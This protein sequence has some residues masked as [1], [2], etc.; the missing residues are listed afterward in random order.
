MRLMIQ[1]A[2]DPL[3]LAGAVREAAW[4][5][6]KNIPVSGIE[7]MEGR[8]SASLAQPRFRML[9]VG[10]FALTALVLASLGVYATLSFFVRARVYELAVRIAVGATA[11]DILGLVL[12]NGLVLI[13]LGVV[14]G[15]AGAVA[16]MR[17]LRQFLFEVAPTDALTM[18]VVT[19]GLLII[20]LCA[21]LVP[22]RRAMR[23]DPREA[24]TA[25]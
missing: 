23:V 9:L 1:T 18:A 16:L 4:S 7:S 13:G 22:A 8:V 25:Q 2:G 10:V 11:V 6:D 24:L 15:L 19:S 21:C 20:A 5:V 17:I 14:V 12:R 3:Q